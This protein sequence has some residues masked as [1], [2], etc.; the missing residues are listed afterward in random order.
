MCVKGRYIYE[1][2]GRYIR[3]AP[4]YPIYLTLIWPFTAVLW[5]ETLYTL[6][7]LRFKRQKHIHFQFLQKPFIDFQTDN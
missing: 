6:C 2:K 5:F 7:K 1:I 3:S 4:I